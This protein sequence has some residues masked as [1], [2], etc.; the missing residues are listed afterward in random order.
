[1]RK[2]F[3][4]N[5]KRIKR[6]RNAGRP[7]PAP[8]RRQGLRLRRR[9]TAPDWK[10]TLA[11]IA[12]GAGGAALG[13]L[14]VNQQI[15]SPEAVG[16]G[17]MGLGGATAYFADGN[18]RVLGNSVAAAGAGQLALA[19]MANRAIG[20]ERVPTATAPPP[21]AAPRSA[22]HRHRPGSTRAAN[23]GHAAQE[24][25]RRRSRHRPLPR[26]GASSSI[27]SMRTS[28][29]SARA[30]PRRRVGSMS[31]SSTSMWT[32]LARE[33]DTN[34]GLALDVVRVTPGRQRKEERMDEDE[35]IF[36]DDDERNAFTR[37]RRPS[38]VVRR[39]GGRSVVVP[40]SRRPT[41]IRQ[42]SGD[43]GEIFDRRPTQ[44]VVQPSRPVLAGLATGEL[45]EMAAQIIAA[46]Q[47][48]PG[49]PNGAGSV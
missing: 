7:L 22:A 5:K 24:L 1:M 40:A 38:R 30:M 6:H 15:L 25:D 33:E 45:I 43:G 48:L 14:V 47:P 13:G 46:I 11:A 8:M 12:G 37:R 44:V 35:V 20:H 32:N 31:T 2:R 17:M 9:G 16:I 3:R 21:P 18:T 19:L 23:V 29:D 42:P 39:P 26:R 10:T 41:I 4:K 27:N 28:G 34:N 49:A 36:I